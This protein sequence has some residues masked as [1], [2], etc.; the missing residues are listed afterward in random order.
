MNKRYGFEQE[1][2]SKYKVKASILLRAFAAIFSALPLA[3]IINNKVLV[4]HGG[5]GEGTDLRMLSGAKRQS[6]VSIL[7]AAKNGLGPNGDAEE[8]RQVVNALWSDPGR[9]LGT[10]FNQT[11]GGGW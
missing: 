2:V 3:C 4:M 7:R 9:E 5:L 6:Y 11:R 8:C 1:V 10:V